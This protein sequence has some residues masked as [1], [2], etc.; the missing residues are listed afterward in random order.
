MQT[1]RFGIIGSGYMAKMHSL[2]LRNIGAFLWRQVP[3]IE[4]VRLIDIVPEAAAEGAAQWGW[5]EHGTDWRTVTRAEDIDAVIIIT[6]NDSHA[7]LA[8]DAFANGKHVFC[9]KPLSNSVA[10]A[11]RMVAAAKASG[12]VNVVNFS[13]R[14]WP[15]I[16]LARQMIEQGDLGEILHFEGH[17]FQDYAAD[18]SLPFGWRFDRSVAGGGAFGDIGSHIMD[19]ACS[20]C[21]PV[22]RIAAVTRRLHEARPAGRPDAR[23]VTV[24]DITASLVHFAS[25]AT[26]SVHASWVA[27]GH[28]SSLAF[29]VVGT[30]GSLSFDWERNNEIQFYDAADPK[31]TAGFR[32]IV[33][34]GIHPEA[35]PFWYA[36]GQGLGYGEAFVITARRMIEAIKRNDLTARPSF[37]EALHVNRVIDAAYRAADIGTWVEVRAATT[38]PSTPGPVQGDAARHPDGGN[39]S[40]PEPSGYR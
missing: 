27:T 36:Q 31:E 5:R 39:V 35:A 12:K 4:M 13:Y 9:E 21:G 3:A 23:P 22:E 14:T 20:L 32:R 11:E 10:D 24:D 15:G 30:K 17:F 18:P 26:G 37:E 25:G 1:I 7:A 28:K 6:P 34:G 16:E 33:L 29:T 40:A 8:I 19:I 38:P 2:A